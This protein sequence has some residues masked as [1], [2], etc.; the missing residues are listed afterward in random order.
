[1]IHAFAIFTLT[2]VI[3]LFTDV[4]RYYDSKP[5]NHARGAALRL[6]GLVPACILGG[7]V[8]IPFAFFGYWVL[9]NGLY[10]VFIGQDWWYVGGKSNLD[11]VERKYPAITWAKYILFIGSIILLIYA[12]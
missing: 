6:L 3:D 5:I 4:R 2:L 7:W 1:M 12:C 9:F 10:N 8:F 11:K